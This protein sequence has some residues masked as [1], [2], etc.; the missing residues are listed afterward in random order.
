MAAEKLQPSGHTAMAEVLEKFETETLTQWVS[1]QIAAITM[2]RDLLNESQLREQSRRFLSAF[3]P[4]VQSG[5]TDITAA[6]WSNVRDVL[7][8]L[9]RERAS[10]GFTTSETATFV[11]S[12]KQ[13]LFSRLRTHIGESKQA[14]DE[15]LWTTTVLLD[16]LGLYTAEVS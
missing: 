14:Y 3:R 9:S 6:P 2:R 12:L 8:D 11:F 15:A 10:Q 1:E 13:P 5:I 7:G 16:K 4:A